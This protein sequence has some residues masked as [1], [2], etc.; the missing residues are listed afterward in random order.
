M[1]EVKGDVERENDEGHIGEITTWMS[2][3]KYDRLHVDKREIY[4]LIQLI[5]ICLFECTL[6]EYL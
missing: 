1:H 6:L 3:I 2:H 4:L 5:N